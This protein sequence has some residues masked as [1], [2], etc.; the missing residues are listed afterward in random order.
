MKAKQRSTF[1]VKCTMSGASYSSI[2]ETPSL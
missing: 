2:S 1:I